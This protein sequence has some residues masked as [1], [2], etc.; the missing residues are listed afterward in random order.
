M[1][2]FKFIL[3]ILALLNLNN[4]AFSAKLW[5]PKIHDEMVKDMLINEEGDKVLILAK[6]YDYF[7]GDDKK[8]IKF[9]AM[10]EDKSLLVIDVDNITAKGKKVESAIYFNAKVKNL[11]EKQIKFLESLKARKY[12]NNKT[13]GIPALNLTGLRF[14][15][16]SKS[17]KGFTSTGFIKNEQKTAI[18]E[19]NTPIQ[20]TGKIILTPFTL[21][22]DILLIP[23]TIPLFM[24]QQ[25][26]E[27]QTEDFCQG[28]F[29]GY[30][31]L[32]KDSKLKK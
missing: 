29:C 7:L 10:W 8:M 21:A 13:L 5:E 1:K 19:Q 23:I 26:K 30:D 18:F 4:C 6:K 28:D 20:T 3:L 9:L 24:Y 27:S 14:A 12:D 15:S 31:K 2:K 25:I 32:P 11:S 16:G 22:A 17:T